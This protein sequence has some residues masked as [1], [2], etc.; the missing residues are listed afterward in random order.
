MNKKNRKRAN[1]IPLYAER[2][3][4]EQVNTT[5]DLVRSQ[6]RQWLRMSAYVLLPLSIVQGLGVNNILAAIL[7]DTDFP[8][9]SGVMAGVVALVGLSLMSALMI[10]LLRW[11]HTHAD[12]LQGVTFAQLWPRLWRSALKCVPAWLLAVVIMVPGILLAMVM[13]LLIPVMVLLFVAAMLPL[14]QVP[15]VYLLEGVGFWTAFRRAFQLGYSRWGKLVGLNFMML[16]AVLIIQ[17]TTTIPM[18]VAGVAVSELGHSSSAYELKVFMQLMVY[19]G[20]VLHSVV[21]YVGLS[22]TVIANTLY[23][24][25]VGTEVEQVNIESEI[26]NFENL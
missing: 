1:K 8:V 17:S 6:W 16:V 14:W 9:A 10:E 25:S 4:S 2:T 11:H 12:G 21:T 22:L 13:S 26:E 24:T 18:T 7:Y 20:A 23:Y 19:L 3:V 15:P 5:F